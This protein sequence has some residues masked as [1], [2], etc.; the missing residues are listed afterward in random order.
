MT[1]SVTDVRRI[2]ELARLE[3]SIEEVE[4]ARDQLNQVFAVVQA[5]TSVDTSGVAPM[6][7]AQDLV[8]RLRADE[9]TEVD[10]RDDYQGVAP[11]V[12]RGLYLVPKV[13]E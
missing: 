13:I 7:H 4:H 12:E 3:L 6:T 1:L 8:L 11:V 9:I 10:R 5:L 2:A